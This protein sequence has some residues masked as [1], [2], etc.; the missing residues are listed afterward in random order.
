MKA[1]K[2]LTLYREADK[3][4]IAEVYSGENYHIPTNVK[5]AEMTAE[6]FLEENTDYSYQTEEL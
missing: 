4:V 2:T 6:Q 5:V 1:K 3:I